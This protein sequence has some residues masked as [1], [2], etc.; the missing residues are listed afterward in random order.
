VRCDREDVAS[1]DASSG[2][3]AASEPAPLKHLK[4][5]EADEAPY[6]PHPAWRPANPPLDYAAINRAAQADMDTVFTF[7]ERDGRPS[8]DVLQL[9][10]DA[11]LRKIKQFHVCY[12]PGQYWSDLRGGGGSGPDLVSIVTW[13]A[14]VP[15]DVA[16]LYIRSRLEASAR[17]RRPT[18]KTG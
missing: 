16:G 10:P 13:L 8:Q 11:P 9:N 5:D 12:Q 7:W 1:C 15:R 4:S 3:S 2:K 17:Y 6:H 14:D 18:G